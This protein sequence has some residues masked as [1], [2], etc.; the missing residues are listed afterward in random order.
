MQIGTRVLTFST[1]RKYWRSE[2]F[3]KVNYCTKRMELPTEETN[4]DKYLTDILTSKSE[5]WKYEEEWRMV[6]WT[7]QNKN[8]L[9]FSP[10]ALKEIRIGLLMPQAERDK[11]LHLRHKKYPHAKV[12]VAERDNYEYK[13]NFVEI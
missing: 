2:N 1:N 11:V 10:D 4:F 5:D 9:A 7:L 12:F 8:E 3:Y 13:I 6:N